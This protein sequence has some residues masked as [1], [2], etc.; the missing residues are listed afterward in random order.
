LPLTHRLY[1]PALSIVSIISIVDTIDPDQP[2]TP[3]ILFGPSPHQTAAAP[4]L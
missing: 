1:S 3:I 4:R 2:V